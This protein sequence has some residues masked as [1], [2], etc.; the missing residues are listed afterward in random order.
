MHDTNEKPSILWVFAV[1]NYLLRR[2][3]RL[4]RSGC[5]RPTSKGTYR[6]TSL[7]SAFSARNRVHFAHRLVRLTQPRKRSDS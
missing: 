5:D 1:L 3:H 7:Y 4:V 2:C 6:L